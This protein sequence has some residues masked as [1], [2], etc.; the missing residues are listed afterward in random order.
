MMKKKEEFKNYKEALLKE[1]TLCQL[2]I[3]AFF[4]F[5]FVYVIDFYDYPSKYM[6]MLELPILMIA[7]IAVNLIVV[8]IIVQSHFM[9]LVKFVE[10]NILDC[11]LVVG[12]IGVMFYMI[13]IVLTGISHCY[14]IISC[15]ILLG[16]SIYLISR[17]ILF[18]REM[19]DVKYS[20]LH[21]L[22]QIYDNII[23]SEPGMPILVRE[24]DVSY[25]LV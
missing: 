6:S 20:N 16:V 17:H 4:L 7:L 3:Y 11:V 22:R 23:K 19:K 15:L 9:D 10:I 8:M 14:K 2:I 12:T 24:T 5:A 13:S 1:H 25:E 21:D 18:R